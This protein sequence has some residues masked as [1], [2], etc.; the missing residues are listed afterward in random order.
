MEA[1][2]SG[3]G[4]AA[5]LSGQTPAGTVQLLSAPTKAGQTEASRSADN[6]VPATVLRSRS[7]PSLYSFLQ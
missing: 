2:A 7:A 6:S 3:D 1:S 5:L 4:H